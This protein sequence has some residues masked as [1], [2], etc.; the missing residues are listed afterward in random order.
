MIFPNGGDLPSQ[1]EPKDQLLIRTT[2]EKTAKA[3]NIKNGVIKVQ[4]NFII[5]KKLLKKF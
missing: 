3:L 5:G 1:L 2:V 4:F